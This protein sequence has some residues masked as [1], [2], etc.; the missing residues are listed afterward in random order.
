LP[1]VDKGFRV[2]FSNYF[3]REKYT[4]E[5]D[6]RETEEAIRHKTTEVQ[7]NLAVQLLIY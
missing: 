7:V 1:T 6:I 2:S 3:N 4:L 5:Q